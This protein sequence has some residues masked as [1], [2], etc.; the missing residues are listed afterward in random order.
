M[1]AD[2]FSDGTEDPD[3]GLSGII[4]KTLIGTSGSSAPIEYKERGSL[5][6]PPNMENLP[7]PE[8][9][10]LTAQAEN[11]P[12]DRRAA[13]IAKLREFYKTGDDGRL[14]PEQMQGHLALREQYGDPRQ[15]K[16][17]DYAAERREEELLDGE[18]LTPEEMRAL[19]ER[20]RSAKGEKVAETTNYCIEN[21]EECKPQR[22]YLTE[23]P[24]AYSTPAEG[25]EV[26]APEIDQGEEIR[27]RR[28]KDAIES[29]KPIDLSRYD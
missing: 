24:L 18:K 12:E 26:V 2:N 5:V 6:M 16:E 9:I 28:E 7:T 29:G 4:Q 19:H 1:S 21:P 23:P 11:W 10:N 25:F 8:Q 14:T 3:A 15:R 17:R 13:E 20:Y 27:A 22:R